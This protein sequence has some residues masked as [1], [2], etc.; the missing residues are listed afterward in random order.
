MNI[1]EQKTFK[2]YCKL[3]AYKDILKTNYNYTQFNSFQR[4]KVALRQPVYSTKGYFAKMQEEINFSFEAKKL[5][6]IVSSICKNLKIENH[7]IRKNEKLLQIKIKRKNP[8]NISEKKFIY[9]KL[10]TF[11]FELE[12][13]LLLIKFKSSNNYGK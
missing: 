10:K 1:F 2:V 7:L 4:K 12:D 6:H 9:K 8:F 3:N 13:N 11:Y 5:E